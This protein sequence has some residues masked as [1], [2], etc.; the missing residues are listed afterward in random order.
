MIDSSSVPYPPFRRSLSE[1][2]Y[3]SIVARLMAGVIAV[4]GD[5]LEDAG[6][7]EKVGFV[8]KGGGVVVK[9]EMTKH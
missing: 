7:L 3:R 6:Q 4:P 5:P 2:C 8:M 9:D 1:K